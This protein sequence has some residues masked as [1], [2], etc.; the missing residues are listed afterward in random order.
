[1]NYSI[2]VKSLDS[3]AP[4]I[5]IVNAAVR[6]MDDRRPQAGGVA[7]SGNRVLAA[8]KSDDI[9][10][11]AGRKTR[12]IDARGQLVLPGFNDAHVHFLAGGFS[13]SQVQLRDASS[14]EEL[15]RRLGDYARK[16]PRGHWILGG[17]WDHELWPGAPLPRREMI[18]PMTPYHPVC[19]QRTDGHMV[20]A[21]SLAMKLSGV[22]KETPAPPGG[23]IL[24]DARGEPGGIFKDTAQDLIKT[25]PFSR[26]EKLG[27][28]RAATEHAARLGVTSLSDMSGDQEA[29]LYQ[30]LA[31]RRELKTRI[32]ALRS[33]ATWEVLGQAGI[34]AAFGDDMVRIGGLKGFADGS[35][36]SAT[37]KFFE[38]YADSP[39][40]SGLWFD[41]MLPPGRMEERVLAAD[42]AGL[43][44]MIHAIGDEANAIILDLCGRVAK[45]N[46]ARDRR[47]RIEHA[48]H[49]RRRDIARFGKQNVIASVQP[50]HVA[51]DGRWCDRRIGAGRSRGAFPFR[52]LLDGGAVLALGTDWTVAPLEPML[53]IQAA[54][55]RQTLDG[56]HPDGWNPQ[57]KIS[58]EEA[59][60]AYTVGSA[61]AEFTEDRK[62]TIAPGKLADMVM[63]D[64]DIFPI[65]P[66]EID[67]VK[68]VLTVMDGR[69]VYE[70]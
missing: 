33:I 52:S 20:L 50:Y 57:E 28:A 35:L 55:T 51:D 38:P 65:E 32:Y 23:E 7:V 18:D 46:G 36:G 45:Q 53:T 16:I 12:V 24:R 25:P 2:C 61:Y 43:Q 70:P 1:M 63:L 66:G 60:R 48:Q 47:F 6:T 27:A 49:L 14:P 69:V 67:K 68:V 19:V 44:V 11:L 13:L 30:F 64:G 5:V 40:S 15:A 42:R 37:A 56:R 22:T 41:Q 9:R 34:R 3:L 26:E 29:G 39:E 10:R 62:G 4:D 21:N 58:V 59:V 54:I 31:Q 8:G 17:D